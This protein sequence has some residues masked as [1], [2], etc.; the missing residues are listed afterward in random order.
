MLEMESQVELE[1][2]R[3]ITLAVVVA[4]LVEME[5]AVKMAHLRYQETVALELNLP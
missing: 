2:E 3:V 4:A 1:Q 5:L